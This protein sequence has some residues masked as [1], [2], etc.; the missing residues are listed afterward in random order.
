MLPDRAP[1]STALAP[2]GAPARGPVSPALLVGLVLLIVLC[3]GALSIDVV[4]TAYSPKGDEATYAGLALSLAHDR[5]FTFERQDLVRFWQIYHKGPEGIF[6]KRGRGGRIYFAKAFIYPLVAAPFVWLFELNGMLLLNVLLLAAACLCGYQFLRCLARPP[7]ALAFSLGFI[8]ASITPI[9]AVWLTP[10]IFNFALVFYA[11]FFWFYKEVAPPAEGRWAAFLRGP[12][13]DIVA[14]VLLGLATYSKPTNV[15]LVA[16]A[17]LIWWTRRHWARGLLI[18]VLFAAVT[19]GTFGVNALVTGEWNYQGGDRKTFYGTFPDQQPTLTFDNTG[20]S[21]ATNDADTGHVIETPK[22]WPQL[23]HNVWYFFVGRDAGFVPYYFPGVVVILLWLFAAEQRRL[24]QAFTLL[25]VAA[26]VLALL[27]FAPNTWAGGGG[28]PG[29]RYF[30]S[31]YPA[32]FFL[33]PPLG[34]V[35][36]ALVVW[37]GGAAFVAQSLVNPFVASKDVWR[38]VD[39]GLVSRL[40]IELTMVSDL[41][42]NLDRS[43]SH[44][45][46]SSEPTIL[47]YLM[48][49]HA[50]PPELGG[51]W[52]AGEARSHIVF[53]TDRPISALTLTLSAPIPNQVYV[54]LG[55]HGSNVALKAGVPATVSLSSS[56]VFSD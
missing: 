46:Y 5:N 9:Y 38:T 18:G 56:G 6:L 43:R 41:P 34:S 36:P 55:N 4:Q 19:A 54:S 44:L 49:E 1:V 22:F 21:K 53:R 33:V 15:M 29:N 47:L 10:E 37:V 20:I 48:D 31:L 16:P 12:S 25:A 32:L 23:A 14:A 3:A 28:P 13:S 7:T 26:S 50:Y 52:V 39:T 17:V 11:Y 24:W 27:I 2:S 30:L 8:G 51:V 40:P 45:V 35:V 42:I